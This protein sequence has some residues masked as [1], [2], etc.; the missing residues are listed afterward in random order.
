M[1]VDAAQVTC[2]RKLSEEEAMALKNTL[3][4]MFPDVD[5]IS[6]HHVIDFLSTY[7]WEAKAARENAFGIAHDHRMPEAER[8]STH[9]G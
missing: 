1:Y 9:C 6:N 2:V 3:K 7:A 5:L 8:S 4:S